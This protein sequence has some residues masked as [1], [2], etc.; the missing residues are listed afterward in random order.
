MQNVWLLRDGFLKFREIINNTFDIEVFDI[1]SVT[2]ISFK[3]LEKSILAEN[4][5]IMSYSGKISDYIS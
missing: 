5:K 1:I 2:G 4:P 3:I